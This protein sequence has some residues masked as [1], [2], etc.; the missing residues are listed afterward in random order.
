[1]PAVTVRNLP[2]ATHRALRVRAALHGRS[3]EA[4][5]RDILE[6]AVRPDGRVK[7]GSVLAD[8]A[9]RAGLTNEDVEVLEQAR[10]K[11]PAEPL[12]FE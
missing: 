1:M 3:T 7:L 12:G 9:R 5:I 4:E 10:D 6:N 11:A 8:I 2:E